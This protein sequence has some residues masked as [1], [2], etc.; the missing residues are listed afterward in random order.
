VEGT[1]CY[2]PASDIST[3][4]VAFVI[5]KLESEGSLRKVH[6]G[7]DTF[8][9]IKSVYSELERSMLNAPSNKNILEV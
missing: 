4:T 6:A 2:L 1:L 7:D 3:Y 5:H 8:F 9:R